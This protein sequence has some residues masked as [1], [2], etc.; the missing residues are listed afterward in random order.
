MQSSALAAVL[1]KIHFPH[2]PIIVAP[3]VLSACTHAVIG[4]LLAGVWGAQ[5]AREEAAR[6]AEAG[7]GE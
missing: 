5:T 4:S 6:A 2:D 1:A 7:K 3:C